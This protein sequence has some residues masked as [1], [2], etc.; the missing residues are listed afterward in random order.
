L[1]R[2]WRTERV[3]L[4]RVIHYEL[5][6][7]ERVDLTRVSTQLRHSVSHRGEIHD[8]RHTGKVLEEH[9]G[10]GEGDLSRRRVGWRPAGQ[11]LDVVPSDRDAILGSEQ[12]FEQDSERVGEALDVRSGSR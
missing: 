3:N 7:L 1:E 12:T 2:L 11:G 6:R 10:G 4:H 9:P 8:S 5:N